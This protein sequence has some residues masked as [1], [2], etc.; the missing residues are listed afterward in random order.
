M[1]GE[2]NACLGIVLDWCCRGLTRPKFK[3]AEQSRAG[4]DSLTSNILESRGQ[5]THSEGMLQNGHAS[6]EHGFLF[7]AVTPD[8]LYK[9]SQYVEVEVTL[10]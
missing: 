3:R 5:I 2:N 7:I 8:N 10:G 4:I 9:M 6:H 1:F